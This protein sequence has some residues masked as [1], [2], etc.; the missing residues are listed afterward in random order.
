[1]VANH[2]WKDTKLKL[3][4]KQRRGRIVMDKA[5]WYKQTI[6]EL[7]DQEDW[8]SRKDSLSK[9]KMIGKLPIGMT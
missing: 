6:Q 5:T 2:V 4:K 3:Q 7:K 9:K 1:M 8:D